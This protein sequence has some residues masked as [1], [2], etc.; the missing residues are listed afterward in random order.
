MREFLKGLGLEKSVIDSIMAEHGKLMTANTTK[1]EE[2][3]G[4]V[5]E[6][7]ASNATL[8]AENTELKKVDAEGL[9]TQISTLNQEKTDLIANHNKALNDLKFEN[10]LE[11]EVIKSG[12]VDP[13][14]L[15]AHIDRTKISLNEK[16]ELVGWSEQLEQAK[17]AYTYLFNE[18]ATGLRHGDD[19]GDS[20]LSLGGA[21]TEHYK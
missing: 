13:I 6:L 3:N 11:I 4:K 7:T 2:L 15:M 14:A 1:I 19:K 16:N 5:T 9:K 18:G 20:T 8:T 12:T 10:A 17:G 21:L